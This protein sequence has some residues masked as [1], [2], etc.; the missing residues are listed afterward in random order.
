[1]GQVKVEALKDLAQKSAKSLLQD[2]KGF[3]DEATV[4]AQKCLTLQIFAASQKVLGI[5]T[6]MIEKA[7]EAAYY[8]LAV[9]GTA[10]LA[11]K[12]NK[13]YADFVT[14]AVGVVFDAAGLPKAKSKKTTSGDK[15]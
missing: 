1:M 14:G 10:T 12:T 9:A 15:E 4:L 3:S 11:R 2:V 8:N 6:T 5:N 7:V 13:M